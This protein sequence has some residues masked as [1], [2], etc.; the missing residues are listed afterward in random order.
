MTKDARTAETR[1]RLM[2]GAIETI[3]AQ[4]ISGVSARSIANTAGVN[5]ALI[6]YHF[7]SVDELLGAACLVSTQNR[8]AAYQDRFANTDNLRDLLNLGRALQH[9]E[10]AAGNVTVLAQMLAGAQGDPKL[11]EATRTALALWVAE[12]ELVL[13]RILAASPIG[14]LAEPRGLARA[15]AASFI[16]IELWAAADPR[17]AE[18]GLAALEQL[19]VLAEVVDNLGPVAR[20]ALK[21]KLR[22]ASKA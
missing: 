9:E 21:A 2:D 19:A 13:H 16:G 17:G 14:E 12:I 15:V 10:R 8:V 11:A 20:R 6:F 22:G 18:D 1:R 4:G 3:R 7:G 5:Q